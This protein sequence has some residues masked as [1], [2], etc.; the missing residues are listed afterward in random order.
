MRNNY[1]DGPTKLFSDLQGSHETGNQ[2][3]WQLLEKSGKTQ[4]IWQNLLT[5]IKILGFKEN[6]ICVTSHAIK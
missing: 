3:T 2:E 6:L 5:N 4:G 1:G